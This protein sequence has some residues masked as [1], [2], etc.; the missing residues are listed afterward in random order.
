LAQK[1]NS[2]SPSFWRLIVEIFKFKNHALKWASSASINPPLLCFL[3]KLLSCALCSA[4]W[5]VT[6]LPHLIWNWRYLEDH[7]RNPDLDR[8]ETMGQF[9]SVHGHSKLFQDA[10]LVLLINERLISVPLDL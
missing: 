5:L 8:S 7:D 10:Y 6:L 3:Y 2:L 4:S 9:I 1:R